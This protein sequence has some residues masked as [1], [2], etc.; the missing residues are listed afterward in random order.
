VFEP[1]PIAIPPRIRRA[2]LTH[3]GLTSDQGKFI[4]TI[5]GAE[6]FLTAD[7]LKQV[8]RERHG[9][10]EASAFSERRGR[11][12]RCRRGG[13]ADLQDNPDLPGFAG[14]AIEALPDVLFIES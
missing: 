6:G 9:A 7:D 5:G 1:S 13:R 11:L 10:A 3:L 8:L 14:A 12:H 4:E 2:L